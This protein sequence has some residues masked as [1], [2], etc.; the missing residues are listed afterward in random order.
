MTG[1]KPPSK[2]YGCATAEFARLWHETYQVP[3]AGAKSGIT[4]ANIFDEPTRVFER[5]ETTSTPQGRRD[6]TKY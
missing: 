2:F 5:L 6:W 1:A 4:F 3:A